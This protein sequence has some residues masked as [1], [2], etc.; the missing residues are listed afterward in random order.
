MKT[1]VTG[2]EFLCLI[3]NRTFIRTDEYR[4]PL[5]NEFYETYKGSCITTKASMA[6]N[7]R[8]EWI[9]RPKHPGHF[10]KPFKGVNH[11]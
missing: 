4:V 10:E 8:K 5:Y 7:I 11:A 6:S 2:P 3:R 9:V 1:D